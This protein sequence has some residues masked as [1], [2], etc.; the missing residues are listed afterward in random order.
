MGHIVQISGKNSKEAEKLL[1]EI[2]SKKN[3]VEKYDNVEK[4]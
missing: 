1:K 4:N 2:S 3:F